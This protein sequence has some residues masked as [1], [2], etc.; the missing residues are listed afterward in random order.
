MPNR[1]ILRSKWLSMAAAL[2]LLLGA[3]GAAAAPRTAAPPGAPNTIP[4]NSPGEAYAHLSNSG[5]IGAYYSYL[6]NI[7][8]NSNPDVKFFAEN[9]ESPGILTCKHDPLGVSYVTARQQ[10]ALYYEDDCNP[11]WPGQAW[12]IYIPPQDNLVIGH[13]SDPGNISGSQTFIDDPLF[14]NQPNAIVFATPAITGTP[15]PFTPPL[16]VRYDT[17]QQKWS[18]MSGDGSAMPASTGFFVMRA[19]AAV[20]AYQHISGS[21][22]R[23]GDHTTLDNVSINNNPQALIL[24]GQNYGTGV[25]NQANNH[26]IGLRYDAGL[27][28]WEVF[29]EDGA[30]M[31]AGLMFNVLIVPPKTGFLLHTATLDNT[32]LDRTEIDDPNLN[33]NPD[34]R[35]YVTHNWNP[36]E[37]NNQ[38]S[39]DHPLGVYYLAGH[40]FI[41]NRDGAAMLTPVTF[42]VYYTWP[43]G[44]SY[45]VSASA[46]NTTTTRSLNLNS[47]ALYGQ[48]L[49]RPQFTFNGTPAGLTPAYAYTSQAGLRYSF[50]PLFTWQAFTNLGA[51]FPLSL[52]FNVL[53]PPPSSFVVSA[54]ADTGASWVDIDNPLTN[55]NPEAR[56]LVTP[57]DNGGLDENN[58]GVFYDTVPGRWGIFHEN[59]DSA[60]LAGAT[61]DVFVMSC[62]NTY[63][64]IVR[65]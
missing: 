14:N 26:L 1:T 29:N 16:I 18:I 38:N 40:W 17:G 51:E 56:L 8:L 12:N 58:I 32:T 48:S 28:R 44:D 3:Q 39:N 9:V 6:D 11:I 42:N 7:Q 55:G 21:A 24:V 31:S 10:W 20:T 34:A 37:N 64:P 61:F 5:N 50:G 25:T 57:R 43:R 59:S 27:G 36:P 45:I 49:A 63:L 4:L 23:S 19:N 41:L 53:D 46:T 47:P 35:V 22:N 13:K 65:K 2:A 60:M 15:N 54:T 62:C 52:T 33:G 30:A